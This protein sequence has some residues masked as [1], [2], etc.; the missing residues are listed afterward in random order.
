MQQGTRQK[1]MRKA[2]M[3]SATQ[4]EPEGAPGVKDPLMVATGK[5]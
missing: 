4:G 3:A 5:K 2:G 1:E